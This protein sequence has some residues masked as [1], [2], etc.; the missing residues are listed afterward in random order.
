MMLVIVVPKRCHKC[1]GVTVVE[2]DG[3]EDAEKQASLL[4]KADVYAFIGRKKST[5]DRISKI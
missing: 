3:R 2:E 5:H 1:G 4:I